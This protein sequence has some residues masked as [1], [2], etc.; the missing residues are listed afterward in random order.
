M[1]EFISLTNSS[2]DLK[3]F[4]FTYKESNGHIKKINFGSKT[5]STYID[6]HDKYKRKNYLNRHKALGEDWTSINAGSLSAL[7]L[8][9][10]SIDLY[11]NLINYLN[12]FNILHDFNNNNDDN[13]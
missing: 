2:N 7:I 4:T 13:Y 3:R 9:G 8:W 6:H 1:K 5:G 12:K 10:K 11:E